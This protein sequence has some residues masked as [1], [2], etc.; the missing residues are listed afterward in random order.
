MIYYSHV[1]C[2]DSDEKDMFFGMELRP[3]QA[4]TAEEEE[5]LLKKPIPMK[6]M[7]IALG[8]RVVEASWLDLS[9]A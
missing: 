1:Y 2:S 6:G 3:L 9:Y 8:R 7:M 5:L 4:V